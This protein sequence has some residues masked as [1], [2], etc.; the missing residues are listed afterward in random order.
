MQTKYSLKNKEVKKSARQDRKIY[1]EELASEA[2]RR[3]IGT[4]YKITKELA[5]KSRAHD[6][7]IKS[8]AGERLA[9][10]RQQMD[11]WIE[12]FKEVLNF[13][14]EIEGSSFLAGHKGDELNIN[15]EEISINEIKGALKLLKNRKSPGV[16]EITAEVLKVDTEITATVFHRLFQHI[17][18][19]EDIPADWAKGIIIKLPKKGDL[20]DCNNWRGI[21]LLSVPG[22]VFLRVILNRIEKAIDSKLRNEQAGFRS[23]RGCIDHIF[24]IRN[25]IEQSIEWQSTTILNFID[26]RKAFDSI[27]RECL[28]QILLAYQI[29]PKIVN[30]IKAFYNN[31][32]CC[33]INNYNKQSDLFNVNSGIRQGCIIPPFFFIV[34]ID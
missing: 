5:G 4:L 2:R 20:S 24:T 18:K 34:T 1:Y 27:N 12:H 30:I 28:W 16:D 25:I 13:D 17:W 32:N 29:P 19:D 14:S 33:I 3:E 10:E 31:Y 7:P 8:K 26:F 21:T 9:T 15:L 11:R 22:K 6:R 23:N